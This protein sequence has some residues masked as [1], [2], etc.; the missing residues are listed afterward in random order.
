VKFQGKATVWKRGRAEFDIKPGENDL[1]ELVLA[2][3]L[4]AT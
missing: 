4:F 3:G 1:G 2:P